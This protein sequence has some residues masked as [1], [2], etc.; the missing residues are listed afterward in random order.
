M[1]QQKDYLALYSRK[2]K[3]CGH[4]DPEEKIDPEIT[5]HFTNGNRWCPASEVQI[6]VVGEAQRFARQVTRARAKRD[7]EAETRIMTK[8]KKRD[9]TF[10]ERFYF[11][12][13]G[14]K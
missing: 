4:L 13:E 8:V 3:T 2:C 5:C 14:G 12:L 1:E 7:I 10:I 11:Y 9:Q 6:A